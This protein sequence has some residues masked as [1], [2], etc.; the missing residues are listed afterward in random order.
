MPLPTP[1]KLP[2]VSR[3]APTPSGYLH[4]GNAVNFVLTWLTWTAP[5]CAWPTSIT[6][7]ASSTGWVS[8]MTTAPAALMISSATIRSFCICPTTTAC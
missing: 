5:A 4:L 1:E 7:S 8:T 3:L 2:V 6:S